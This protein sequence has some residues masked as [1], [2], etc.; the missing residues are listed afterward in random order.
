[1]A[2]VQKLPSADI[3]IDDSDA[4]FWWI[5]HEP[6]KLTEIDLQEAYR[7]KEQ[8]E[9]DFSESHQQARTDMRKLF[10]PQP[11]RNL[12]QLLQFCCNNPE[13]FL[14]TT[15]TLY[16]FQEIAGRP[17]RHLIFGSRSTWHIAITWSRTI[18]AS[19][20]LFGSS[21]VLGESRRERAHVLLYEQFRS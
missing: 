12:G 20:R 21:N 10:S 3:A 16:Q 5:L 17:S 1:M 2:Y 8:L 14:P 18:T 9:K 19:T 13:S 6:E 7:W 4:Q 15:S 11:P